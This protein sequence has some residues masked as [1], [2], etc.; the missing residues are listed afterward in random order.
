MIRINN[1]SAKA[2]EFTR[3]KKKQYVQEEDLFKVVKDFEMLLQEQE[4][5]N[6]HC[7]VRN[8]SDEYANVV[9]AKSMNHLLQLNSNL[10]QISESILFFGLI[11]MQSVKIEY[12]E[13]QKVD[14]KVPYNFL[15]IEKGIFS[16]EDVK[17]KNKLVA[18]SDAIESDYLNKFANTKGHFIGIMDNNKYSETTFGESV[19]ETRDICM[20]YFENSS[21]QILLNAADEKTFELDFWSLVLER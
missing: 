8:D 13:I 9:F 12:H 16:L 18:I 1:N 14:F 5:I 7:L 11:D 10:Q 20:G 15:C 21:C 6:F 4:G 3:F 17:D 19:E 2:M